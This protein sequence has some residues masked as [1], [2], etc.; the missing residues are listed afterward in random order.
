MLF[1]LTDTVTHELGGSTEAGELT[2]RQ[3]WQLSPRSQLTPRTTSG[4]SNIFFP[5]PRTDG[6]G[7][8]RTPRSYRDLEVAKGNGVAFQVMRGMQKFRAALVRNKVRRERSSSTASRT[9]GLAPQSPGGQGRTVSLSSN[10]GSLLGRVDT[11][12][13]NAM[14]AAVA[15]SSS[16]NGPARRRRHSVKAQARTPYDELL[17]M[18]AK[19]VREQAQ[20][21]SSGSESSD[22][23]AGSDSSDN[24]APTVAAPAP[25]PTSTIPGIEMEQQ[26][27]LELTIFEGDR[28]RYDTKM[29]RV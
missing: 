7:V 15:L 11:T 22:S 2:Q 6:G 3:P 12:A 29:M 9:G 23:D 8:P 4:A 10:V 26:W 21:Q 19:L 28:A 18:H 17:D 13:E 27:E 24:A 1:K 20:A 14:L 16:D 25:A 5:S